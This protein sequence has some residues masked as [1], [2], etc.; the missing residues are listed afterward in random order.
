MTISVRKIEL[1][2]L[3]S[4]QDKDYWAGKTIEE[5]IEA[6]EILRNS[7]GK[8]KGANEE[9]GSLKRFRRVLRIAKLK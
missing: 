8:M 2:D 3:E 6:I 7:F 9:S 1:K 4:D 5:K